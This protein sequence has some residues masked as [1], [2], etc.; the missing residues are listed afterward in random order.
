MTEKFVGVVL[1]T[2]KYSDNLI[3]ADMFTQ[4]HGRMSFLVPVS[5]SKHSKVRSV[6]FQPLSLLSFNAPFRQGKALARLKDVQPY[7]M[8][9]SILYDPVKAS[10]AM[11]IAE[12]LSYVLREEGEN[13]S[14]FAFLDYAFNL[15]DAAQHGYADFHIIFLV[16]LTRFLG[17]YPNVENPVDICYFDMAAGS[18]VNEH[19]MHSQFLS[20]QDTK[21]FIELLNLD[22]TSLGTFSL[23][24]KARGEYLTLIQNYYRLHIPDFP[25]LKSADILHELFN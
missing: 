3:I 10:I 4:S 2:I 21:N 8:Y 7:V 18:L 19:P 9:S 12:F 23:N 24:R 16:Q 14:L 13:E 15:F 5:R 22:L 25:E 6:L 1:R 11:Y 20:P 17:I